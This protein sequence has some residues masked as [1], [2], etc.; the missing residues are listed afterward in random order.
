MNAP[1]STFFFD[2]SALVKLL[3]N[4]PGSARVQELF[5]EAG[6]V[7]SSWVVIAEALGVLKRKWSKK[8][9]SESRYTATVHVFF[10]Y[11]REQRIVAID[12][13]KDSFGEPALSTHAYDILKIRDRYPKLDV[14]DALQFAVI[15]NSHLRFFAGESKTRLVSADKN[16]LLAAQAEGFEVVDVSK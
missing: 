10:A 1:L 15:Q 9:L 3:V 4:E 6:M 2:A 12:L 16:L 13:E 7:S 8:Q 14:A 11:I 5:N